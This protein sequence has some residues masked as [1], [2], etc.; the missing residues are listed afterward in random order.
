VRRPSLVA[1]SVLGGIWLLPAPSAWAEWGPGHLL[2]GSAG[3][4]TFLGFAWS[5]SSEVVVADR[6]ALGANAVYVP[7]SGGDP[8]EVA[9][10]P[11]VS[12]GSRRSLPSATYVTVSLLRGSS[13]SFGALGLG[14]ERRLRGPMRIFG[15]A[16]AFGGV[17]E[18]DGAIS[19]Y[20]LVGVR[21][22]F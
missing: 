16:G 1:A 6:L 13:G 2:S 5:A 10:L 21:W 20:A 9:I 19:P 3:A 11:S 17:G 18:E 15:E 14:Y 7:G 4:G 22:R 12:I 8:G